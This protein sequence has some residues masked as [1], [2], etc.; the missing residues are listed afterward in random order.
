MIYLYGLLEPDTD[1]DCS[2]IEGIG[3]VTGP[4]QTATLPQ[5]ILVFGPH[6]G[7]EILAKRRYLL[8][9]ARVLEAILALGTVLPMRFGMMSADVTEI[10]ALFAAQAALIEAQQVKL[11]N[12]VEMGLRIEFEREP[13]LAQTLTHHGALTAERDRL[14]QQKGVS[15]FLHAEF[16]RKLSEALERHRTDAQ[17]DVIRALKPHVR[18]IMVRAPD[19]DVQVLSAHVLIH[20][21]DEGA[22]ADAVSKALQ[23]LDFGGASE[24]LIKLVG[25]EPPYH[26][27]NLSLVPSQAAA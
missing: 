22:L 1:A 24:P 20:R 23:S 10:E 17:R 3:G 6:D 26:F 25:P 5:G 8:A 27:V 16:G 19:S 9:H 12:A 15:H 14:M 18:D 13:A 4:V 2:V 21:D 11:R 7:S